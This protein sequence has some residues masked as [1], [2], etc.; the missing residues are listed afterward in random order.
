MSPSTRIAEVLG[1]VSSVLAIATVALQ[2]SKSSHEI[3]SSFRSQ[4]QDVKD[5]QTDLA[6]LASILEH[7]RIQA[8]GSLNDQRLEVLRGPILYCRTILQ[9]IHESLI[10]YTKHAKDHRK[11]VR[12]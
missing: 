9:D 1:V 4:Y 11:S 2:F 5:V 6:N 3:I 12:T 10:Q 7:V 8:E